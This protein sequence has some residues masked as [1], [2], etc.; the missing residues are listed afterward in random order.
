MDGPALVILSPLA[1]T[2][3]DCLAPGTTPSQLAKADWFG[4]RAGSPTAARKTGAVC[5]PTPGMVH[6]LSE[7]WS[8]WVK[9]RNAPGQG[10]RLSLFRLHQPQFPGYLILEIQEEFLVDCTGRA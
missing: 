4:K 7:G 6:K 1:S 2:L 9:L 8:F 10:F 3:E 5:S